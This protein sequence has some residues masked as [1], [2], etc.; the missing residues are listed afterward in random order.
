MSI[1]P[2]TVAG[3]SALDP[4][5]VKFYGFDEAGT[6]LERLPLAARRSL[7]EAGVQISLEEWQSIPLSQREELVKSGTSEQISRETVIQALVGVSYRT[8]VSRD[9]LSS[10][11]PVASLVEM[12]AQFGALTPAIW[13]SLSQ[14]D[15][16]ALDKIAERVSARVEAGD[17]TRAEGEKRLQAA[18]L[19]IVGHTQISTHVRA[20]GGVQM[21]NVGVKA[22]TKRRAEAQSRVAMSSEAFAMLAAHQVPKGDVLAT[23]RI[24]GI[25]AAK[26]TSDLI[27]LCHVLALTHVS[28]DLK[29]REEQHEVVIVACVETV[30]KTGVEMEALVAASTAALTV[31]DMLKGTDRGMEIGPTRLVSK[32]GGASGDFRA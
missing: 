30:G 13:T 7:D 12:Y 28:V 5:V 9:I 16:Y 27:P 18:Y 17:K 2:G 8:M 26:R 14:L 6:V 11:A 10:L 20:Q 4:L 15:R 31:Y 24:A 32:S 25:M 21:V 1:H 3:P 22:V 19:E 29:L 23:A